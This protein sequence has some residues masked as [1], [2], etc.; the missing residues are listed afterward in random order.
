[1]NQQ[2]RWQE[3]SRQA[4]CQALD[5]LRTRLAEWAGERQNR[6]RPTASGREGLH[7][8]QTEEHRASSL[9]ER[10]VAKFG[11]TAFERDLLLLCAGVEFDARFPELM[12]KLHGDDRVTRTTFS[13]ALSRLE[14]PHWS[15]LSPEGPLR[16]GR[17]ISVGSGPGLTTSPLA[18]EE[19]VLHYLV[20]LPQLDE[21]LRGFFEPVRADRAAISGQQASAVA[22]ML[23]GWKIRDEAG[24]RRKILL[25]GDDCAELSAVFAAACDSVGFVP[26]LLDVRALPAERASL[27]DTIALW[28]RDAVLN[29]FGLWIDARGCEDDEALGRLRWLLDR[30]Q[31][32]VAFSVSK[33][34]PGLSTPVVR[35]EIGATPPAEQARMWYEALGPLA[36]R[37]NGH[38]GRLVQQFSL[39]PS[40][41]RETA[42][43]VCAAAV[44]SS[45]SLDGRLWQASRQRARRGL[46]QLAQRLRPLVGWDDLVLPE[47]QRRTLQNIAV[48]VRQRAQVYEKWGF[49]RKNN[50]GLGVSALFSG[51]SGVGKTMAAEV[52]A[53]DL[54]LDLYRIDL[55]TVVSKYIGETEKNLR[56]LFDAAEASGA[57]LLFD[58]SD[59]LFGKRS[60]VKD[61]HD[62]YANLE[63]SYLLQRMESYR[64]LAIL[65]TN[66]KAA[67]DPAFLRRLRFIVQ[68][69]FPSQVE[70]RAIWERMFPSET[71][72]EPLDFDKLARL[73]VTGGNIANIALDAAFR[74]AEEGAS[75]SMRHL[76]QAVRAEYSKIEKPLSDS[77]IRGWM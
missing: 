12:K 3:D 23:G 72:M 44:E 65:T 50:R 26:F 18:I 51:P 40:A 45:S 7:T 34:V 56:R 19:S 5:A 53:G 47:P 35:I 8:P 21:R 1:M 6:G 74:A 75:V 77:E 31:G 9:L 63:I 14:N 66:L 36:N 49:A 32:L 27:E 4:L 24:R 60:E 69:P 52:L 25:L 38:V 70:R 67:L 43:E 39:S 62:R 11:L 28:E 13:L 16:R 2:Q 55:S 68:F 71:P 20:G 41:I 29:D 73:S 59:A 37:L 22:R 57:I 10:L 54:D 48:Q 33:L 58:E 64:G 30:L 15:A 17:L 46:N 76:L 61:S 42:G